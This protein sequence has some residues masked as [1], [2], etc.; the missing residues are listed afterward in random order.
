MIKHFLP[1]CLALLFCI[2]CSR[3]QQNFAPQNSLTHPHGINL[4]DL[5]TPYL[6][7]CGEWSVR[8]DD[9]RIQ[10]SLP[11][12]PRVIS[13]P[14]NW[15]TEGLDYAGAVFY[16]RRFFLPKLSADTLLRL[17]FEGVDYEAEVWL[18]GKP[19]GKHTGYFQPFSFVVNEFV[20][21]GAENVLRI[22]VNS[23]NEHRDDWSLRKRLVKGIFGHHD[24]RPGGAWS[25]RGQDANTGG[26]WGSV[27]LSASRSV[28][29]ESVECTPF[30]D[31]TYTE[32]TVCLSTLVRAQSRKR[33][34][35]SFAAKDASG[36]ITVHTHKECLLQA[37]LN[38][39][40]DTLRIHKPRLWYTHDVGQPHLYTF[41]TQV[42][43]AEQTY[44][45]NQTPLSAREDKFGIRE[46]RYDQ[47]TGEWRL[48]GKRLF[49]RGTNYIGTQFLST[50][51]RAAYDRD[52]MQ[53]LQANINAVR[54]HAHIARKEW[55][56][57][58]D[59]LGLL[60]WQDFPLQW[61]YAD[62]A[63]FV[64]T[65]SNQVRAMI[66]SAYNHPS[67]AV[68]CLHN[69]PPFDA[70]WMQYKY[71]NYSP[72]QN[73][74]LNT[75]LTR[76]ARSLDVTRYVH[77][78]SATREHHWEGWYFGS[79]TAYSKPVTEHLVTEFG[80]QALP[81]LA[82]LETILGEKPRLPANDADW[83]KWDYHNFQRHETFDF[84]KVAMGTSVE[85]FVHNSQEHQ[86]R[87]TELAAESYRLQRYA[88][89]GAIFQFMFVEAWASMNW[90]IVD[91]MRNPKPAYDALR[92]AYQP[93][94]IASTLDSISGNVNVFVINDRWQAFPK[95]HLHYTL[96]MNGR[97][98]A[99]THLPLLV[100]AD[101]KVAASFTH[102]QEY[103]RYRFVA[104]LLN[105]NGDTLS[106]R[107]K[108]IEYHLSRT[109][110][111]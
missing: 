54:V 33:V 99:Q 63:E 57:A 42:Y 2:A 110:P 70:D 106:R 14:A 108:S 73:A 20:Q 83:K 104:A 55:Y 96:E 64:Q 37:G 22:R 39:V 77:P 51:S 93:T 65:A 90:G 101:A 49:L 15:Y 76:I 43:D 85:E 10:D 95:A 89:V 69:E 72:Q 58:C 25:V 16:E 94:L 40:Y 75:I 111:Q 35:V 78:F 11:P 97:L 47:N 27:Y 74:A 79:W 56:D 52:A 87:V 4:P 53:M 38:V 91:Y 62:D 98:V 92:E 61:G 107:S 68:W 102:L 109:K 18:N 1:C 66:H 21:F 17:V 24:T 19:L 23:P 80:A 86:R 29:I 13:V 44:T 50:M 30:L 26:I 48:N 7:L 105:D 12:A 100:P 28:A 45:T 84:A 6:D 103:G 81:S 5:S 31:S 60:L 71:S 8:R 36:A 46:I 88:P 41:S 82:T 32:A 67:I 59:S 34:R 9:G 3:R